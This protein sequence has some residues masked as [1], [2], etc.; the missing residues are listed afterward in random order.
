M[1]NQ[2]S[3]NPENTSDNLIP[4]TDIFNENISDN[5][6]AEEQTATPSLSADMLRKEGFEEEKETVEEQKLYTDSNSSFGQ[7]TDVYQNTDGYTN[8]G[9]SSYGDPN[10]RQNDNP[11]QNGYQNTNQSGSVYGNGQYQQ[12]N[13]NVN[14]NTGYQQSYD[15]NPNTGYQSNYNGSSNAGY[16]QP[17]YGGSPKTGYQSNYIGVPNTGYQ[18]N[19]GNNPN[20][21]YNG[22]DTSPLTMGDWLLTLLASMIPCA[23][24]IL[25]FIWA[26]GKNGNV[27]R[28]NFCR[29]QLIITGVLI[30]IYIIV[31]LVWGVSLA[32]A[33]ST[34]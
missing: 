24:I 15:R 30:V 3:N 8:A 17:N 26:F 28:R 18:P 11:Y 29:A 4:E 34:Y 31:I 22:M 23:G 27:N 16:Q 33:L 32:G 1:D 25:V 21:P 19:Y 10:Q 2:F 12:P 7:N 9:Q 20:S 6:T 5:R 13:Y 14:G